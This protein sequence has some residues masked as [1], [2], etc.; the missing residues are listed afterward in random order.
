MTISKVSE[1][2]KLTKKAIRYYESVGL[3]Q[4]KVLTNG[5]RDYSNDSIEKL[6]IIKVLRQLSFSIEEIRECFKD[7]KTLLSN[8]SIKA[9][10][11]EQDKN[12]IKNQIDI[13]NNIVNKELNLSDIKTF[14]NDIE[15]INEKQTKKIA[16]LLKQIFPGDFGQIITA[17]YSPFL[18]ETISS[19]EQ[20]EILNSLVKELDDIDQI[21]VPKELLLWAKNHNNEEEISNNFNKMKIDYSQDYEDFSENK[22]SVINEYLNNSEES[23]SFHTNLD[24][25]TFLSKKGSPVIEI[26]GK[27]LPLLSI[28][29]QQFFLK[30]ERF[31]KENEELIKKLN[32]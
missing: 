17:A 7:Q 25:I 22:K 23:A 19:I 18:Y 24:L 28:T 12:I 30:Q 29:Y 13:I 32:K 16:T 1:V 3:V 27:Y 21:T 9:K 15:Q 8:F 5:Y 4:S 10:Q 20:Q 31:L 2:T 14:Q 6:N 26:L 11:L